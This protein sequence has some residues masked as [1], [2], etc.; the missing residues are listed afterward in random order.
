MQRRAVFRCVPVMT[1]QGLLAMRCSM[2][3][4]LTTLTTTTTRTIP[5]RGAV[6]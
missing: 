1:R 5:G 6:R 4:P 3:R 2:Q